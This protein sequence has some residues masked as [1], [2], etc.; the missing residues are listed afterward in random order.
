MTE[1]QYTEAD[2]SLG[3]KA[4]KVGI[5]DDEYELF[6]SIW[7]AKDGFFIALDAGTKTY[8]IKTLKTM[9]EVKASKEME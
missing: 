6:D 3:E 9:E 4:E 2:K 5:V 7:Q 1:E 8:E